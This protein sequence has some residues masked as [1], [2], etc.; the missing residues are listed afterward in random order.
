MRRIAGYLLLF[1]GVFL[2]ILGVLAKTYMYPKLAK[3]PLDNYSTTISE[4]PGAT[5]LNIGALKVETGKLLRARRVVRGDVNAAKKAGAD[6]T[7]IYDVFVA[8]ETEDG[9]LVSSTTDRVAFDRKTTVA[10][11]CCGENV[12]GDTTVK[13]EGI[14]YKFPF[15]A[16]KTSYQY[17]DISLRKATEMKYEATEKIHGLTVYK[18]VQRIEPTQIAELEV[19]GSLVGKSEATVKTG[20]FYSNVRT[21]WV[22]PKTGAIVKGAEDQL[23]TLRD[24]AG[25]DLIKITETHLV[26]TEKT[27]EEQSEKAKEA[28]KSLNILGSTALPVGVVLGLILT[29]LGMLLLRGNPPS[30]RHAEER[31]SETA[32]V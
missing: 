1:L 25:T 32:G 22:E 21:A 27:I 13:H 17:F 30:G 11:N 9:S 10:K 8:I 2:L 26:F 12:N 5:Y 19:P 3:A 28:R 29:A 18:Y 7:A 31:E 4:A 20:R 14:E 15:D 16:K 6:D 24:S 23:S